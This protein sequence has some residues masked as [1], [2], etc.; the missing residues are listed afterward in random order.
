MQAGS[1]ESNE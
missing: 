1:T